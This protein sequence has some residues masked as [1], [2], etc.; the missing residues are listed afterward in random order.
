MGDGEWVLAGAADVVVMP[1]TVALGGGSARRCDYVRSALRLR[2]EWER[3]GDAKGTAR[4]K[5]PLAVRRSA[6]LLGRCQLRQRDR[7][8]CA[9][10]VAVDQKRR[11]DRTDT[12]ENRR[13][14]GRLAEAVDER[15][16][17]TQAER[18]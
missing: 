8:G 11:R 2:N 5:M 17:V 14:D 7:F 10:V 18:A 1:M 13:D 9:A 12:G 6:A 16:T 4:A 15:R 3:T